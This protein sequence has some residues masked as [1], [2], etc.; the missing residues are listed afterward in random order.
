MTQLLETLVQGSDTCCAHAF[1]KTLSITGK[2]HMRE[3]LAA[4]LAAKTGVHRSTIY[5]WNNWIIDGTI[6]PCRRCK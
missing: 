1:L 5:R 2:R 6:K 4:M 3:M